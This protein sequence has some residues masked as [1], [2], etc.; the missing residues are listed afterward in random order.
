MI[1]GMVVRRNQRQPF[2]PHQLF[3]ARHTVRR[4]RPG[5]HDARAESLGAAAFGG[6]DGGRHHDGRRHPEQLRRERDR[7]RVIPRRRRDHAA[8]ARLR[9]PCCDEK[10]YAPRNLNAPPRCSISGLIQIGA[11]TASPTTSA[12]SSGVRTATGANCARR[13]RGRRCV[14]SSVD[15]GR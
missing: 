11:P 2:L 8:L 7:L 15:N 10:L 14:T 1:H 3:G 6:G 9:R 5:E 13:P 4:R 12:G